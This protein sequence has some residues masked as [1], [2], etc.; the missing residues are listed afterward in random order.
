[1]NENEIKVVE[2]LRRKIA[3][4]EHPVPVGKGNC[5]HKFTDEGICI[6]CHED[7]EEWDAGC[8]EETVEELLSICT[9]EFAGA[10][11]RLTKDRYGGDIT[12]VL[13]HL[14]IIRRIA[15][16]ITLMES[17]REAANDVVRGRDDTDASSEPWIYLDF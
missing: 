1:M 10:L 3:Y 8:V 14:S 15:D 6:R 9:P 16:Q 2:D 12:I 4:Y 11:E 13:D 5:Y 17:W 7:A